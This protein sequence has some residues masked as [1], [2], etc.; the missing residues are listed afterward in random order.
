MKIK[1][2]KKVYPVFEKSQKQ[3]NKPTFYQQS[4][5]L[6]PGMPGQRGVMRPQ[7]NLNRPSTAFPAKS[8]T[9]QQSTLMRGIS[10]SSGNSKKEKQGMTKKLSKIPMDELAAYASIM[11]GLILIMIAIIIW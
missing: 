8:S 4:N 11:I 2:G 7:P 6:R 1:V 10:G 9:G 3:P 5:Q